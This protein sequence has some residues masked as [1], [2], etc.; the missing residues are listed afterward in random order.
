M[1]KDASEKKWF[2][3]YFQQDVKESML[4][5]IVLSKWINI[6]QQYLPGA[7]CT[8]QSSVCCGEDVS[9]FPCDAKTQRDHASYV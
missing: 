1:S 3:V 6:M 4:K 7:V 8:V 9:T 5:K 2:G